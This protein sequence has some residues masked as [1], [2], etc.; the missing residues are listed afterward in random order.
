MC[1]LK[2]EQ[3]AYEDLLRITPRQGASVMTPQ[4]RGTVEYVNILKGKVKVKIESDK[5]SSVA[6]FDVKDLKILKKGKNSDFIEK[7]NEEILKSLED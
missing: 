2:Y 4:G 3:E 6:E 1:C 7:K 5:E